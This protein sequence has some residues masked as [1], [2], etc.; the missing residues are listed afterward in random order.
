METLTQ[1]FW[2]VTRTNLFNFIIFALIILLIIKKIDLKSKLDNS[3]HNVEVS[4]N[5]SEEARVESEEKLSSMENTLK[6]LSVEIDAILKQF[7]DNAALVGEKIISDTHKTADVLNDNTQKAIENS[8]LILKND[9]LRRCSLASVEVAKSHIIEE[10]K[11]NPDLHSKL[12]EQSV[13]TIEG[14]EL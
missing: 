7:N 13:N 8:T 14:A 2:Y 11:R 1:L 12:I 9:I 6:N 4:I 3:V 10:L 5:E